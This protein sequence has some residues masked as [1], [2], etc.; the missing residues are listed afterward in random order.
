MTDTVNGAIGRADP[1]GIAPENVGRE[2]LTVLRQYGIDTVFGIPG[3][4]NLEFYRHLPGLGIHAV[5]TRHEQ[6]AGYAADGW[7]LQSGLPGVVITTSGPGLLNVLSAAA[8]AY[9]ES[10]PLIILTPGVPLGEEFADSGSLHETKDTRAAADAVVEWARRVESGRAAVQAVHDAFELFRTGRPRPVVIE[11]PLDVLEGPRDCP[12]KLIRPRP[13]PASAAGQTAEAEKAAAVL[14]AAARPAV[15]AGGG[16]LHAVDALREL[17]ERLD[18]PVVTTL[19][20]RGALPESHPLAA[21]AALRLKA[22]HELVNDAD[23]L[24]IVGS[25]VGEA[26]MWWGPLKPSGQVIRIDRLASQIQKNVAAHIEIVGDSGAV[27]PQLLEALPARTAHDD[28]QRQNGRVR[29]AQARSRIDAEGREWSPTSSA[30]SD[31][32]TAGVPDNVILGADSSQVCYYGTSNFVPLE[33]PNSYLYMATHAT[34]GYGLPACIGAKIASPD[35]PVVCVVGDGALMFSIQELMT[36]VEQEIDLVIVCVDNGGY[37]EIEQNEGARGIDPIGVRLAQP[38]W[39]RLTDAFGGTGTHMTAAD[40]LGATLRRAIEAGAS[41]CCTYR[42]HSSRH[43]RA[44]DDHAVGHSQGNCA[45][46][47]RRALRSPLGVAPAHLAPSGASMARARL[48][49]VV[50]RAPSCRGLRG[51]VRFGRHA[52]SV[53]R[54]MA[55]RRRADPADL[56]RVRRCARQLPGGAAVRGSARGARIPCARPHRPALCAWPVDARGAAG[57]AARDA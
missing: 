13:A 14:S 4:H 41:R 10:R 49:G 52:H 19:N 16:S 1:G 40:E 43:G 7:A 44:N 24:L 50:C 45:G 12:P 6:G 55:Q 53:L 5:T 17:A 34:L 3:T 15:L 32:I 30:C 8:T 18:S 39:A 22:A 33:H 27:V 2:V 29:A 54:R 25:K 56:R 36:A 51:R 48:G 57:H 47:D 26:E 11:V 42:W 20:G 46:V 31:A 28:T 9:A 35:R 38:D 23:A 21:G 37:R